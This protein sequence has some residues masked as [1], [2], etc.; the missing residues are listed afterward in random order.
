MSA[1]PARVRYSP[2]LYIDSGNHLLYE[3]KYHTNLTGQERFQSLHNSSDN[4]LNRLI[5]PL[6]GGGK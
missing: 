3:N 6:K 2:D 1:P 5:E 4:S